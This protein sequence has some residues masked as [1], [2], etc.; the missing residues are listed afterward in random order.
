MVQTHYTSFMVWFIPLMKAII[1][2]KTKWT[3]SKKWLQWPA[4]QSRHISSLLSDWSYSNPRDVSLL[5]VLFRRA[6]VQRQVLR[7]RAATPTRLS[8]LCRVPCPRHRAVIS[9]VRVNLA[10][11]ELSRWLPADYSLVLRSSWPSPAEHD[12]GE[13]WTTTP[14]PSTSTSTPSSSKSMLEK[15]GQGHWKKYLDIKLK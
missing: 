4:E 6:A 15:E 9:P 8:P 5:T 3:P 10:A 1:F 2:I 13:K 14:R 7:G 12:A 11:G